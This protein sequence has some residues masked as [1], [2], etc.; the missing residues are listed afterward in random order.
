MVYTVVYI[1]RTIAYVSPLNQTFLIYCSESSRLETEKQISEIMNQESKKT[2]HC[3]YQ[4]EDCKQFSIIKCFNQFHDCD[5]I[6]KTTK[7]LSEDNGECQKYGK[8]QLKR[9]LMTMCR[10]RGKIDNQEIKQLEDKELE[11]KK[12]M[13]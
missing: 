2:V 12:D 3:E 9:D 11:K 5:F 1:F 7:I 10:I 13:K 4:R 8:L 6:E